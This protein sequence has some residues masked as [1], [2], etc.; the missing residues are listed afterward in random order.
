MPHFSA[1]SFPQRQLGFTDAPLPQFAIA[2][3]TLP[4]ASYYTQD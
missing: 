3:F 2:G 4:L 1:G